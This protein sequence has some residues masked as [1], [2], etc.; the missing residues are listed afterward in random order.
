VSEQR[1]EHPRAPVQLK[2]VYQRMNAFIADYAR[3]V[4]RGGVF[5]ET[6]YPFNPGTVFDFHVS[7]PSRAE[8][9]RLRGVVKWVQR[10]KT[11]G[12]LGMGIEFL[13]E[14]GV[15]RAGFDAL[16]EELIVENLGQAVY[17]K[18]VEKV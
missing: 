13:W 14:D 1:R 11:A 12:M 5:V 4:S 18:L 15:E 9:L 10:A 17:E 7:L 8:T 6:E 3:N 2:I 16:V